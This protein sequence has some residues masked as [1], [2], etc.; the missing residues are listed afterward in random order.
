MTDLER[1]GDQAADIADLSLRLEAADYGLVSKHLPA[2]VANV[3]R[4]LKMQFA[5]SSSAIP[6]PAETF[7]QR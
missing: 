7:E 3:K 6:K 1:M 5:L 4:W 2:M